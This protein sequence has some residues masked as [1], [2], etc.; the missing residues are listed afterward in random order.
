V[1]GKRTEIRLE[2]KSQRDRESQVRIH[3]EGP[4]TDF[5]VRN[6]NRRGRGHSTPR[7][8]TQQNLPLQSSSGKMTTRN[9]A[10]LRERDQLSSRALRPDLSRE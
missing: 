9:V 6:D 3:K 2:G 5:S 8:K 7:E 4:D 1:W 10:S